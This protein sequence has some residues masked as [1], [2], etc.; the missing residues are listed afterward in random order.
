MTRTDQKTLFGNLGTPSLSEAYDA[1][2]AAETERQARM[3]VAGR[4]IGDIPPIVNAARRM[5]CRLEF[6]LFCVT[7]F[8]LIFCKPW[9][10]DH[11][12]VAAKIVRAVLRGDLFAV[13]MPR[14]G[15]K[16]SLC[17]VAVLWAI[18]YGHQE[19]VVLL[20]SSGER[21][22]EFVPWAWGINASASVIG[23]LVALLLA[24]RLGFFQ[25]ALLAVGL[26][27]VAGAAAIA[28]TRKP[29]LPDSADGPAAP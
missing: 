12:I 20:A 29:S 5:A 15:G 7:Y 13:A 24:I 1:R 4:D 10:H 21:A 2:K 26:Y 22:R 23:T 14:G 11:R 25:L 3:A 27:V 9:S 17:M 28:A 16:T 6:L 18:L 19:F 8:P